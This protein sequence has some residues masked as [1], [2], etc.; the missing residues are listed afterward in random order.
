MAIK[1]LDLI[2]RVEVLN[3]MQQIFSEY[4]GEKHI[5]YLEK[6]IKDNQEQLDMGCPD[7]TSPSPITGLAPW[8]IVDAVDYHHKEI[9]DHRQQIEEAKE[10]SIEQ[11]GFA[12]ATD[13][14]PG[15]TYPSLFCDWGISREP[16][17][18]EIP[19]DASDRWDG[20]Y[21]HVV[22]MFYN[23]GADEGSGWAAMYGFRV[24]DGKIVNLSCFAN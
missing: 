13:L 12:E 22:T 14:D 8:S 1:L 9:C 3:L 5:A 18:Y 6:S 7:L 23:L 16:I 20:K 24:D 17:C 2:S 21:T 15:E 19:E 4:H 11:I 10:K